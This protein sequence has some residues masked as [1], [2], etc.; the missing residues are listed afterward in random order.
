MIDAAA[1]A[2]TWINGRPFPDDNSLDSF[3]WMRI[4]V[5]MTSKSRSL[6]DYL[7]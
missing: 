2:F 7:A 3:K 1:E 4:V 6:L 5:A